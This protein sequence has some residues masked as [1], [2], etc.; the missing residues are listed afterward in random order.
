MP[1]RHFTKHRL[2]F[3]LAL[4]LLS[5]PAWSADAPPSDAS[6]L[7]LLEVMQAQKLVDSMTGQLNGMMLKSAE[8]ANGGSPLSAEEQKIV[9]RGVGRLSDLIKQQ[10][11]WPQLE[12]MMIDIYRKSFSQK[13]SRRPVS[14]LSVAIGRGGDTEDARGDAAVDGSESSQNAGNSAADAPDRCR[15]GEGA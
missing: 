11:S 1:R 8:Q 15:Y 4:G 6:I 10:I 5:S 7:Q 12:P 3:L 13:R 9:E 2:F 14:V